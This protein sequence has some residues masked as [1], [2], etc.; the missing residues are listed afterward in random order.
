MVKVEEISDVD[1]GLRP[2]NGYMLI[3]PSKNVSGLIVIGNLGYQCGVVVRMSG[4]ETDP[5]L[6]MGTGDFDWKPGDLVYY[7]DSIEVD[8]QTL[9][10]W[11]DV[12]AF[13]RLA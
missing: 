1:G 8:N 13:K 9:V 5:A 4:D 12:V 10:H 3:Q 7:V 6:E 11:T 2:C